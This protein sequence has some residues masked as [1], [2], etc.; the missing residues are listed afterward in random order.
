MA[1]PPPE[2]TN[3]TEF[4]P[5]VVFAALSQE[6]APLRRRGHSLLELI[7]TGV[8][9]RNADRTVRWRLQQGKVRSV[10]GIGF[11]GSLAPSLE[12]GDLVVARQ[13]RGNRISEPSKEL[14]RA[15][16]KVRGGGLV[17]RFGITTT[18]SDFVCEASSKQSL[19]RALGNEGVACVD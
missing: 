11:A 8:G 3:G 19:A 6:L 1:M 7:K 18:V 5:V 17:V 12:V 2:R 16:E 14:L 10:L 4:S 9:I 15:A 13:I